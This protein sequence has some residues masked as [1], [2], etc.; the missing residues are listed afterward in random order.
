MVII[1]LSTEDPSSRYAFVQKRQGVMYDMN[2]TC[3]CSSSPSLARESRVSGTICPA[4]VI[5]TQIMLNLS[6]V[7]V[8]S[9]K[10][11]REKSVKV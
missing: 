9:P 8:R 4:V 6:D 5:K 1:Y 10:G 3:D 2:G 7:Y 11:G